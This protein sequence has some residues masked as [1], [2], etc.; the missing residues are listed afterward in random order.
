MAWY[1]ANPDRQ[2][3]NEQMDQLMDRIITAYESIWPAQK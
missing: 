1:D 3:L 2:V